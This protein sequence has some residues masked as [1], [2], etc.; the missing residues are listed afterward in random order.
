MLLRDITVPLDNDGYIPSSF[1][2]R[3]T[4]IDP[5]CSPTGEGLF[6]AYDKILSIYC[7]IVNRQNQIYIKD[8]AQEVGGKEQTP[9]ILFPVRGPHH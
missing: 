6:T 4:R 9:N 5:Y 8:H 3:A 2:G 7:D 1:S